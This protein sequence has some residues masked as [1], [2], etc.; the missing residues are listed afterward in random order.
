LK[1][2]PDKL[3]KTVYVKMEEE[4]KKIYDAKVARLQ[5]ELSSQSEEDY[6]NQRIK[7]LAELMGL[8]QICCSPQLCYENYRG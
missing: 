8:R 6:K 1:D 3:E 5:M 7:Y 4:Q 2:L